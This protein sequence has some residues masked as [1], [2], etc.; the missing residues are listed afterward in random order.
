MCPVRCPI[1]LTKIP[2]K[3]SLKNVII[4][5]TI[6]FCEEGKMNLQSWRTAIHRKR[7]AYPTRWLC[8]NNL[9]SGN[10]LH[11]GRG[12]DKLSTKLLLRQKH[13]TSVTE[14]DPEIEGINN[15]NILNKRYDT[16][17]SNFVL[18]V[19]PQKKRHIVLKQIA[20]I[21]LSSA[22]F[23][24]RGKGCQGYASALQNW[25]PYSDGLTNGKQFQKYYAADEL[26]DELSVYFPFVDILKGSNKSPLIIGRGIIL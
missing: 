17:I 19:L 11:H 10:V 20:D 9:I 12:Y 2:L 7:A 6:D 23:A 1:F 5:F 21:T 4:I 15:P 8:D 22:L 16:V 25:K 24:V 26:Y 18:N 3:N 14:Y 13:A